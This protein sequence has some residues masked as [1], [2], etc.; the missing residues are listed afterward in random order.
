MVDT[1]C[2]PTVG[3]WFCQDACINCMEPSAPGFTSITD[4]GLNLHFCSHKCA[5]SFTG[6]DVPLQVSAVLVNS[7]SSVEASKCHGEAHKLIFSIS[8]FARGGGKGT[9]FSLKIYQ[10]ILSEP[11]TERTQ[12][13][14]HYHVRQLFSQQFCKF[15]ISSEAAPL[16]QLDCSNPKAFTFS[17]F[18]WT[19]EQHLLEATK[20]LFK[21]HEEF[22][23]MDYSFGSMTIYLDC[24]QQLIS[25]LITAK[26]SDIVQHLLFSVASCFQSQ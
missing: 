24:S 22:M 26:G 4:D 20:V 16:K 17:S 13:C 5:E 23:K 21:C 14:A 6:P 10:S 3:C 12:Y 18:Y 1:K 7:S 9:K 25:K 2:P 15:L 19:V 11:T 8:A